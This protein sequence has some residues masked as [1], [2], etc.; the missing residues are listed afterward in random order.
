[1][2]HISRGITLRGVERERG[3]PA[4]QSKG[5]VNSIESLTVSIMSTCAF[6]AR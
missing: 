1:M 4:D 2:L 6:V 5:L 3:T